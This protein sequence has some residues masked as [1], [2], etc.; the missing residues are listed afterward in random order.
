[1][2][3]VM[4]LGSGELGKEVVIALQRLG[5]TVIACDSYENAPAMQVADG[6]EVFSMLDGTALD[7]A[8]AKHAPDIIVPEVESI[9]TDRFYDY[10]AQGIQGYTKRQSS[11]FH[12]EP[13]ID[14]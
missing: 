9:R 12:N 13:Q 11:Q 6:F 10:E 5:H 14:S 7:A 3:K 1:M 2:K 4:L 8:V